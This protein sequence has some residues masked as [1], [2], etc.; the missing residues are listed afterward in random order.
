MILIII[1]FF[2]K[3][4]HFSKQRGSMKIKILLSVFFISTFMAFTHVNA[5]KEYQLK[6]NFKKGETYQY[7][8][9]MD[10]NSVVQV[11]N[12]EMKTASVA[13]ITLNFKVDD[14][15]ENKN[16]VLITAVDSG[17]V[18]VHSPMKDTTISL[19]F[20][21]GKRTKLEM[22]QLGK[23]INKEIIDTINNPLLGAIGSQESFRLFR[24]PEKA[25]KVGETWNSLDTVAM[26]MM[27]GKVTNTTNTVNTLAG[28]E[29]IMG[30]KCLKITFTGDTKSEGNANVMGQNLFLEGT[31]KM[32][33]TVYIEPIKGIIV[34]SDSNLDME[35][36]MATTGDQNMIIPLTQT[37]KNSMTIVKK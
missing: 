1:E 24:L 4:Y 34:Q 9:A 27:G 23:V 6:Y 8:N 22:S 25:I 5:Q 28:K 10:L 18:K 17:I 2:Q 31:G 20:I 11:M 35:M 12:Q 19:N 16:L 14:V 7:N 36:T 13:N 26:D 33:G 15:K 29:D 21:A 32:S 37:V 3:K 30:Y